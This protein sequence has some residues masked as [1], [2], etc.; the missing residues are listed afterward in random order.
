MASVGR[1]PD[2]KAIAVDK[3]IT[4]PKDGSHTAPIG[5]AVTQAAEVGNT[6]IAGVITE[7][8]GTG[9]G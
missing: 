7:P 9:K 1:E 2:G 8:H 5:W 3:A 4:D 6:K